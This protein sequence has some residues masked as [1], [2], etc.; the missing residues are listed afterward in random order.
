MSRSLVFTEWDPGT[1]FLWYLVEN[2]KKRIFLNFINFRVHSI[3]IPSFGA[4]EMLTTS[5][6]AR[7]ALTHRRQDYRPTGPHPS[8]RSVSVWR[9]KI[10]SDSLPSTSRP[11]LPTPSSLMGNTA[12]S[13]LVVT[14]GRGYL[15][16][17]PPCSTT[18][19]RKDSTLWETT[20]INPKPESASLL[21]RRMTV[22]PVIPAL[23]LAQEVYM[24]TLTR[25]EM[26]QVTRELMETSTSKP[27]GTSWYSDR[28]HSPTS[29]ILSRKAI[30]KK[31]M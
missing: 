30:M 15:V 10:S 18:A 3:T 8:P 9:S 25:V 19:I 12:T 20:L 27:L 17:R 21:T 14:Y 31:K 1:C 16:Q 28:K 26:R 29:Q 6:E 2:R 13:H 23:V 22:D 7:L 4:T 24:M 11:T 5:Q